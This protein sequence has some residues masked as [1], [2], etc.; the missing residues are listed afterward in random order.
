MCLVKCVPFLGV[1]VLFVSYEVENASE[2][3][4]E[5]QV[6]DNLEK[7]SNAVLFEDIGCLIDVDVF[8]VIAPKLRLI[9]CA[10]LFD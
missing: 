6:A 4:N 9:L 7:N 3:K 8:A 2:D 1:I 10:L 5:N